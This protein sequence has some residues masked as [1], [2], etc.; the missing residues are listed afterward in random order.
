MCRDIQ[1]VFFFGPKKIAAS[2]AQVLLSP[3]LPLLDLLLLS[4]SFLIVLL[5]LLLFVIIILH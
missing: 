2:L 5:D 1:R 4:F 3:F